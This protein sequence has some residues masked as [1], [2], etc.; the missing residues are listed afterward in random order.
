MFSV[1]HSVYFYRF[2]ATEK[3]QGCVG[4]ELS[5]RCEEGKVIRIRSVAIGDS[6]CEGS[7]CCIRDYDCSQY[8]NSDH[9]TD[10]HLTCDYRQSCSVRVITEKINCGV[11]GARANS[12]FERIT[13][14]CV[15]ETQCKLTL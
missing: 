1:K 6:H 11:Y 3:A 4:S 15:D 7:S 14:I 10:V 2:V 5:L 13:Y 8:A 9:R 12:D